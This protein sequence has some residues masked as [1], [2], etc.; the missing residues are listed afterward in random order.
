MRACLVL[1]IFRQLFLNDNMARIFFTRMMLF[2][3]SVGFPSSP[4][5]KKLLPVFTENSYHLLPMGRYVFFQL[6]TSSQKI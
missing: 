5:L 6:I 3:L 4:I 2:G 1:L